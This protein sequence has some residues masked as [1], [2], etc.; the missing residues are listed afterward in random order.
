MLKVRN[1]CYNYRFKLFKWLNVLQK[2]WSRCHKCLQAGL[3]SGTWNC[4]FITKLRRRGWEVAK[5][6]SPCTFGPNSS[7]CWTCLG[8]RLVLGLELSWGPICLGA[9]LVQK[10]QTGS[11]QNLQ[12]RNCLAARSV[13]KC[14]AGSVSWS[15][16]DNGRK[17]LG[18][19]ECPS[20]LFSSVT[21]SHAVIGLLTGLS[22][23]GQKNFWSQ[24]Q[25]PFIIL[26]L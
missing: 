19:S 3:V 25:V 4:C 20:Y 26:Q 14:S 10:L 9:G 13:Q 6:S 8:A 16:M 21:H 11:V 23:I 18:A 1:G 12:G 24:L 15:D 17:Y 7:E 5:V 22:T 2:Q